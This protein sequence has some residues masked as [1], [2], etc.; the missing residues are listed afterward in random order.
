M[1]KYLE[2]A[3]L[4]KE[5]IESGVFKYGETLPDQNTL[6]KKYETSR[7]T[8]QKALKILAIEG[9]IFSRQG[10]GTTVKKKVK[11]LSKY[12]LSINEYSGTTALLRGS[13]VTTRIISFDIHLPNSEDQANLEIESNEPIY[14]FVRL[15]IVDDEPWL[16]EHTQ[17]PVKI[18]AS[19]DEE[20]L[21][22][23]VYQYIQD[24]LKLEIGNAYKIIRAD[25]PNLTDI[26]YL[27][28]NNSTP[29]L[30]VEQTLHL[31]DGRAFDHSTSRRA[32]TKGGV[33]AYHA[34]KPLV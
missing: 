30:E 31:T 7:V 27:N 17:M 10:S 2:I 1:A 32:F 18:I 15:R 13:K 29:I 6:A 3:G 8:I 23:S 34:G 9:L 24:K 14:D 21:K 11:P 33:V 22:G 12:D 28:I 5:D 16:L 26:E 20:I 4:I 19:L 25:E